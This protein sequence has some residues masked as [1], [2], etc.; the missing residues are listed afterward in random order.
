MA[1]MTA[2][3]ILQGLETLPLR[4]ARHVSNAENI[5]GFLSEHPMVESINYPGLESHPDHDL[6]QMILP[7]GVGAL[8]CREGERLV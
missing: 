1:P 8:N 7:K 5:V 4:M 6:A 3:Q 2:F